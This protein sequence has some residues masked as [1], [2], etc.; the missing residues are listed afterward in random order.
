MNITS[1]FD[2]RVIFMMHQFACSQIKWKIGIGLLGA[3]QFG[4]SLYGRPNTRNSTGLSTKS[5]YP[6]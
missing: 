1:W 6:N 5:K 4:I 2:I 3:C